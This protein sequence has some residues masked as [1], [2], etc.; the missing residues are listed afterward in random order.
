MSI[1]EVYSIF[2]NVLRLYRFEGGNSYNYFDFNNMDSLTDFS[3]YIYFSKTQ[4]HHYYYTA[5]RMKQLID[6]EILTETG[7]SIKKSIVIQPDKFQE[8]IRLI[9][10]YPMDKRIT[11]IEITT[12]LLIER[13][14]LNNCTFRHLKPKGTNYIERVDT[15]SSKGGYGFS[16]E[17]LK[18]LKLLT[19]F[20]SYQRITREDF[21]DF[22]Y[23]FRQNIINPNQKMDTVACVKDP[24]KRNIKLNRLAISSTS[25]Y[26]LIETLEVIVSKDLYFPFSFISQNPREKIKEIT[27]IYCEE[28]NR[29]LNLLNT[30]DQRKRIKE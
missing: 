5:R 20:Y 18:V 29:L 15:S 19:Y 28:K 11:S 17:W 7:L 1:E 21:I 9:E 14:L 26:E 23:A 8:I 24:T 12:S 30:D 10:N 25:K 27:R 4:K 2:S 22:V 16:A 3:N 13:L 6:R